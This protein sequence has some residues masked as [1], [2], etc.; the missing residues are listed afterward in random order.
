MMT[1]TLHDLRD[2]APRYVAEALKVTG[3]EWVTLDTLIEHYILPR[4]NN[5]ADLRDEIRADLEQPVRRL[6]DSDIKGWLILDAMKRIGF[7]S[8]AIEYDE[9]EG[10]CRLAEGVD[11]D[12]VELDGEP[13]IRQPVLGDPFNPDTGI[14]GH[15]VRT[16]K[17]DGYEELR[18]SM[19]EF[20]YLPGHP[21]IEDENGVI[22][23]GHRRATVAG[24]L[25]ITPDVLQLSFGS[26][27]AADA[28]RLKTAIGSNIGFE[29]VSTADRQKIALHLYQGK[30]WS[31]EKIA[32]ALNV[33]A[34]T[35]SRDLRN[36]TGVKSDGP[37]R[38]RPRKKQS[39]PEPASEE[40]S[41][42]PDPVTD[43]DAD[44]PLPTDGRDAQH[45]TYTVVE[46]EPSPPESQG[47]ST[48][49]VQFAIAA[50]SLFHDARALAR[51]AEHEDFEPDGIAT[52]LRLP[53]PKILP[54]SPRDNSPAVR[55]LPRRL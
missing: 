46:R 33:S 22:I 43:L 39:A 13:L 37:K 11:A 28:K 6:E 54:P 55:W 17:P 20:G 2:D 1:D 14:F 35:V 47:P 36:L 23:A 25:G 21:I 31:M 51:W 3:H 50:R 40:E 12:T 29:P 24:D 9:D 42:P 8:D 53:A 18:Q 4:P 52:V 38:G 19:R 30:R 45:I 16:P 26:G 5:L 32:Q 7:Q 27:D 15:N 48:A 34:M 41:A 10:A 49:N 44:W